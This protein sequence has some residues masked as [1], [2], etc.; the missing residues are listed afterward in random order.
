MCALR[1][2]PNVD[3]ANVGIEDH[4][5]VVGGAVG[6][7]PPEP[8]PDPPP[9][10]PPPEGPPPDGLGAAEG[11]PPPVGG[12]VWGGAVEGA[13]AGALVV[14]GVAPGLPECAAPDD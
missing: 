7:P 6:V 13:G 10:V 5:V 3:P 2:H 14:A 8:P 4:P 12:A 1:I 9:A 11:P